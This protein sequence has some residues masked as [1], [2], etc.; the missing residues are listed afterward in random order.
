MQ[1]S[2][3]REHWKSPRPWMKSVKE[4]SRRK[5]R[6]ATRQLLHHERY[7]KI[8]Q[9]KLVATADPWDWD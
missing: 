7:D 9:N 4:F 3:G 1:K 8:P 2:R 5:N 6:Q